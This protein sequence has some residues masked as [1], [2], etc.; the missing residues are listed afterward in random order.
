MR[1]VEALAERVAEI[2]RRKTRARL[3]DASTTLEE[4]LAGIHANLVAHGADPLDV[5]ESY[6]AKWRP[7]GSPDEAHRTSE[8]L[9]ARR[10][11]ALAAGSEATRRTLLAR[12]ASP[13]VADLARFR[14]FRRR[15]ELAALAK[16]IGTLERLARE[17]TAG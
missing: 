11:A 10:P 7:P 8:G 17:A 9:V 15:V 12:H 3:G 1:K 14:A 4:L 5:A 2:E 13:A 16:V 6:R